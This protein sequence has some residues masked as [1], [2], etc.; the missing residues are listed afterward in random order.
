M[1]G[2]GGLAFELPDTVGAFE[3]WDNIHSFDH[4]KSSSTS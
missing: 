2:T 4:G 3:F 1:D